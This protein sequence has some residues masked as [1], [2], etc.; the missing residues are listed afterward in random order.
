MIKIQD[1]KWLSIKPLKCLTKQLPVAKP[2]FVV[3]KNEV[4]QVLLC[5]ATTPLGMNFLKHAPVSLATWSIASL[6]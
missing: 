6:I 5:Q 3:D 4:I 1:Y 2:K